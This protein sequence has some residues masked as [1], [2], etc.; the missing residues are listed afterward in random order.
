MAKKAVRK[1]IPVASEPEEVEVQ[2]PMNWEMPKPRIGQVVV[3]YSRANIKPDQA[4][5]GFVSRVGMRSIDVTYRNQGVSDCYF[6]DDPRLK[7]N[8]DLRMD[9]NGLWDW[10]DEEK[11]LKARLDELERRLDQLETKDK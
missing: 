3:F 7:T 1:Q 8:P 6:I 5:I 10:C 9:V 11:E 4:D 2:D